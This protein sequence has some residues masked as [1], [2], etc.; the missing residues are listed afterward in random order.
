MKLRTPLSFFSATFFAS[1]G[2]APLNA[3]GGSVTGD[4]GGGVGDSGTGGAG[5][6]SGGEATTGGMPPTG[7]ATWGGGGYSTG[8]MSPTGGAIWGGGAGGVLATGGFGGNSCGAE[9]GLLASGG[10]PGTGGAIVTYLPCRNPAPL[11]GPG[12]ESTGYV[13]CD[14][15]TIH[16]AAKLACANPLPRAAACDS[17]YPPDAGYSTC[18]YDSD[19][20]AG[21][22]GYC[23]LGPFGYPGCQC[24]YG[25]VQDADCAAGQICLCG[26][27][28]GQC[29][30]ATCTVD[31][32]C[33]Q[34]LCLS[35]QAMP[36]CP[37]LGF[38]C[39]AQGDT[40]ASD[41]DCACM[42]GQCALVGAN[43][44]CQPI[45][46]V[47]GRPFL[48]LG[49]TRLAS[50]VRRSDWASAAAPDVSGL[51]TEARQ[52]LTARWTEI[53]LME[54][55]SIAAFAR[56]ALDLLSL[57]APP[58]LVT[59]T[60][61]AMRDETVHARDAFALAS[62]YAGAKV[63]PGAL[64]ADGSLTGRSALEIFRT[65][66]LEGCIGETVAA[67]EATESLAHAI[68]PTVREVLGRVAAD[69]TRHAELAWK[70]VQWMM[71]EGPAELRAVA[72]SELTLLVRSQAAAAPGGGNDSGVHDAALRAHGVL[73]PG[74]RDEI[75]HRVLRDVVLPCVEA[76]V[77]SSR[78]VATDAAPRAAFG[79]A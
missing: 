7:G 2:I 27:P 49:E 4:V 41:S 11:L 17:G 63:G 75:R 70:F 1:L 71:V 55:A 56:F 78:A 79:Q 69:E 52:A 65:T 13:T 25:C 23:E 20:T 12:G 29:V 18:T 73:D 39:Q 68:D 34:G 43:H 10:M 66:V 45:Q 31:Q 8:G 30:S 60:Q 64:R 61:E 53:G 32:D 58:E 24:N 76:L 37:S 6:G 19:C 36:G 74:T 9:Y 16:R 46:C 40:C 59:R 48:V 33:G 38:S 51:G 67:V 50:T 54:H 42:A 22:H 14:G 57:G 3:C 28:V 21:P 77:R 44:Q 26:N 62:A 72:A 15:S 35:Y 47:V 5:G